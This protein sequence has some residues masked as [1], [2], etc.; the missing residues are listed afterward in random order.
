M[1]ISLEE[2]KKQA[3]QES[4]SGALSYTQALAQL[5]QRHGFRTFAALKA[6]L[7]KSSAVHAQDPAPGGSGNARLRG[8]IVGPIIIGTIRDD[9][10]PISM[11]QVKAMGG[12]V[13]E[14]SFPADVKQHYAEL[15]ASGKVIDLGDYPKND[16]S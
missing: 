5:S 12:K 7:A 11:D 2:L 13:F 1:T 10:H 3:R 15:V 6:S 14:M 9:P 16:A 8:E 4:R